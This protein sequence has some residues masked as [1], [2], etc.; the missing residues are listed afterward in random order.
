[1]DDI[2]LVADAQRSEIMKPTTTCGDA[3]AVDIVTLAPHC[4]DNHLDFF[5]A[6]CGHWHCQNSNLV[7]VRSWVRSCM[8]GAGQAPRWSLEG[9]G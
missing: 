1:L 8:A 2:L 4:F 7:D 3:Y 6:S 5:L 9:P